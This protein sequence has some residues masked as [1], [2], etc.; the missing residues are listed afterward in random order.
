MIEK[1]VHSLG[2]ESSA[3]FKWYAMSE[4]KSVTFK[5]LYENTTLSYD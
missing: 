4:R 1:A 5:K 2:I 3:A